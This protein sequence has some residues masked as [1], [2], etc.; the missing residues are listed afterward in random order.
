MLLQSLKLDGFETREVSM[1]IV[2]NNE[3]IG[4]TTFRNTLVEKRISLLYIHELI[5]EIINLEKNE[6]TGKID[7]PKQCLVGN[8]KI[9]MLDGTYKT[10]NQLLI[11]K[12]NNINNYV[13]TVN[14]K[15]KQIEAKKI[16]DVWFTGYRKDLYK[17]TL[18][19]NEEM[20]CTSNHP[21]MLR[22]GDYKDAKD[23]QEG[24]SL[25]PLYTKVSDKGLVGYRMCYNPFT[26]TWFYEHRQFCKNI[27]HIKGYV[28]HHENY[29]KLDNRP[30]NLNCIT[31]SLHRYIHNR[32]QS[33]AERNK[34]K[35][36][37]K[38]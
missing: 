12:K 30:S 4:Y 31:I 29:N 17:I 24:E 33:E 20:I 35:N 26:Q 21:F 23:L 11:N 25:M 1:D 6:S 28:V 37:V 34:R 16:K 5:R 27:K 36:S 7:H 2:K 8:T 3:D 14:E 38:Q 19:N 18:D 22:N 15:T 13:Y 32:N 10:I 9:R